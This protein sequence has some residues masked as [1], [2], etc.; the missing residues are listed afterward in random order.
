MGR[1]ASHH[2][3]AHRSAPPATLHFRP[4]ATYSLAWNTQFNPH[5]GAA[6]AW[7][8]YRGCVVPLPS[9]SRAARKRKPS[10]RAI[11]P[12]TEAVF[13]G[14][15]GGFLFGTGV[16]FGLRVGGEHLSGFGGLGMWVWGM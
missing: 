6:L 10:T 7:Y 14:F 2:I 15:A 5:A 13:D 1:Y 9:L 11:G 8:S 3:A 12:S 16:G 4:L